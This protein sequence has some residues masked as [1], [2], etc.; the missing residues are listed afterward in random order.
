MT[1]ARPALA[2][3]RTPFALWRADDTV[4]LAMRL[5]DP[6]AH[7]GGILAQLRIW[8][9]DAGLTLTQVIVNGRT[10]EPGRKEHAPLNTR[11]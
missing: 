11:I 6:E 9:R 10:R 2:G 8:L 1:D 7:T 4:R 5:R 3:T